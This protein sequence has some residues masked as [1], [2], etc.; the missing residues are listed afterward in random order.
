MSADSVSATVTNAADLSN[1][2][3]IATQNA[4]VSAG[5]LDLTNT[6]V[7]GI[8][9]TLESG[10]TVA[11]DDAVIVGSG[12]VILAAVTQIDAPDTI[13]L[14][15]DGDL[16]VRIDSVAG[17]DTL[18]RFVST[19][20][21]GG[22]FIVI[23][24]AGSDVIDLERLELNIAAGGQ[25]QV[26]SGGGGDT[27]LYLSNLNPFKFGVEV[28]LE[29]GGSVDSAH[30]SN[31][32]SQVAPQPT[33]AAAQATVFDALDQ[34]FDQVPQSAQVFTFDEVLLAL[35]EPDTTEQGQTLSDLSQLIGQLD[36][37]NQASFTDESLGVTDLIQEARAQIKR[38]EI[39][40][41]MQD[42]QSDEL[43]EL[44]NFDTLEALLEY[45]RSLEADVIEPAEPL[46]G[47]DQP[48]VPTEE[49]GSDE[50]LEEDAE[51]LAS[52]AAQ[53]GWAFVAASRNKK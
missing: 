14:N 13:T 22:D 27:L 19:V 33:L 51:T 16:T 21:V 24:G 1:L 17:S 40:P 36:E 3:L 26:Q 37:L 20:N 53:A 25:V 32:Q 2:D 15:S 34:V 39:A 47:L 48:T 45:L 38:Q 30:S 23:G 43:D 5:S 7:S 11:L 12:D 31:E 28:A 10:E 8:D 6:D 4:S 35:A 52:V 41:L 44:E 46:E 49:P 29:I 18:V 50:L 42:L 9:I